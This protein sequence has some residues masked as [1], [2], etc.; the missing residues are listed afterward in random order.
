M[1]TKLAA[2][3]VSLLFLTGCA[4]EAKF[5]SVGQH[6]PTV[7]IAKENATTIRVMAEAMKA[8]AEALTHERE[9]A[10]KAVTPSPTPTPTPEVR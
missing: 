6:D 1:N 3:L 8:Q 4:A 9:A 7:E 10:A 5:R 2:A